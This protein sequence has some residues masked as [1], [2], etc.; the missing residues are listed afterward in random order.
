MT[1]LIRYFEPTVF[2]A[3][4]IML[5]KSV[6]YMTVV[7]DRNN[8]SDLI[9]K[10]YDYIIKGDLHLHENKTCNYDSVKT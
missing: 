7:L 4:I 2:F 6:M 10:M 9:T 8:Y 5:S 1:N 3:I